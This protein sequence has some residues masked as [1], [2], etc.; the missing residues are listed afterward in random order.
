MLA[1]KSTGPDGLSTSLISKAVSN[2][3]ADP[4]TR[5]YND[6]LCS[7]VIPSD[8]KRSHITPVHMG[9]AEVDTTIIIGQLQLFQ[10]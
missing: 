10:L 7:G 4:L 9:R 8:W 1:T 5:L 6:S 2:E 3:I